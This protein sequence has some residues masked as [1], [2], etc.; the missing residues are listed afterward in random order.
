LIR[1]SAQIFRKRRPLSD[2]RRQPFALELR[3]EVFRQA[4]IT[5]NVGKVDAE[6]P[7][8]E[9]ADQA[10]AVAPVLWDAVDNGGVHGTSEKLVFS[11]GAAGLAH[12]IQ[13]DVPSAKV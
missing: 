9:R 4:R 12:S 6:N 2:G 3:L 13:S 1:Q 5:A 10:S 8:D 7:T 11:W